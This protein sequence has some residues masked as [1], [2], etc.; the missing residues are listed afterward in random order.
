MGE[1]LEELCAAATHDVILAAPFI[2]ASVLSRLAAKIA[3][4][5][6]L[7]IITRWRVE[8]IAAGV[9]DLECWLVA[10]ARPN[11]AFW[12]RPDLHAKFYR[13]D[14]R[15]LVG[16]ANLTN[17]A[18]GWTTSPN[19]ELWVSANRTDSDILDFEADLFRAASQVDAELFE[20]MRL[21]VAKLPPA[22]EDSAVEALPIPLVD[23][24]P[25]LRDP[26][27]LYIGYTGKIENLVQAARE[28]C[29]DDLRH[30]APPPG[31]SEEEFTA[32]VGILLLQMP[33]VRKLDQFVAIP[34]RF[35]EVTEFLKRHVSGTT[36][37]F[38]ADISWQTLMRWLRYFLPG[39]Y[40][41][42]VPSHSEI[43]GRVSTV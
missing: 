25:S 6:N 22:P 7:S 5:V 4:G 12:L 14:E 15:C 31:L 37:D 33:L 36:P 41:L 27:D 24:L 40:E 3:P 34:R 38:D 11:S 43:F 39:R 19:L 29:M 23:W 17:Q 18:L 28:A 32:A 16:S 35:G 30:L 10:A 26:A 13:F 21:L 42:R 1:T 2:K 9:S 20:Y 8:E